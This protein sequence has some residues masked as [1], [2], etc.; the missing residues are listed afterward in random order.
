MFICI[1]DYIHICILHAILAGNALWVVWALLLL[2]NSCN[3]NIEYLSLSCF[4]IVFLCA[5]TISVKFVDAGPIL[6][7][8]LEQKEKEIEERHKQ[9]QKQSALADILR[10]AV[11]AVAS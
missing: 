2:Q 10:R 8:L 1:Y 5:M 7:T 3:F 11:C 4:L 9:T 6:L